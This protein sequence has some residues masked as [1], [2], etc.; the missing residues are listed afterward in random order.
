MRKYTR[1][2]ILIPIIAMIVS[3]LNIVIAYII[4]KI[5]N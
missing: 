3:I 4:F 2:Q 1:T 5:N